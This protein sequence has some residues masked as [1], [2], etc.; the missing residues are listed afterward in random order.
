M[1]TVFTFFFF[2]LFSLQLLLCPFIF[3]Q[4]NVFLLFNCYY[5]ILHVHIYAYICKFIKTKIK[6]IT[7]WDPLVLFYACVLRSGL[8]GLDNLPVRGLCLEKNDCP[9]SAASAVLPHVRFQER[10]TVDYTLLERSVV[11]LSLM[12][13]WPLFCWQMHFSVCRNK[14]G[15][16]PWASAEMEKNG[17]HWWHR[18]P[19]LCWGR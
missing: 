16:R 7:C 5:Y 11:C 2:S 18:G 6:P 8:L 12:H 10:W 1:S 15:A 3:C 19:P 4:I 14:V 9:L 13:S 17:L